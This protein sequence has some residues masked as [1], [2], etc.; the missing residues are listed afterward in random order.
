MT[1]TGSTADEDDELLDTGVAIIGMAARLPGAADLGAFWQNLRAGVESIE[2]IADADLVASGI[3]P[4]LLGDPH[5]VKA[6]TF[7]EGVD[8]FDADFF[9][10]TPREARLLDPQYR[11]ML[12]CAWE[13]C[14]HAGYDPQTF[15]GSMGVFVGS[16][17][18]TYQQDGGGGEGYTP[19][20]EWLQ[21]LISRD[22][23]YLASQIAHKLNLRG[24]CFTVQTA[25]STSLVAVHLACQ[26]V[27]DGS[28][29]VALAGG[30]TIRLP[31]RAG[32]RYE[33][34]GLVSPDGHCRAFDA[35]A[36]GAVY[37]NGVGIVALKRLRR[38]LA[39][40]DRIRAVIRGSAINND[41]TR[42]VGFMTPG[43]DGQ[44]AVIVEALAMANVDP[45]T[46]GYVECQ[47][48]GA[49]LGDAIE[50]RALAQAFDGVGPGACGI[51]SV[52]TNIGHLEAAAGVAALIKTVL[53]L[54]ARELPPTLHFERANPELGLERTPFYVVDRLRPWV[55]R[56]APRRAGVSS[57]GI[58]GTNAHVVV[59]EAP[60]R[61]AARAPAPPR[62]AELVV[63]SARTAAALEAAA[64]RL[65][66]FVAGHPEVALGDLAYSAATTRAAMEHRLALVVDSRVA[67]ESALDHAARGELV[68]GVARGE[69]G[70]AAAAGAT[71][72]GATTPA[73]I[74]MLARDPDRS[75][76][77]AI[78]GELGAL[79]ARG[80]SVDWKAVFPAGGRRVELP[81]YPFQRERYWI[82]SEPAGAPRRVAAWALRERLLAVPEAQRRE[83][84][85]AL[86]RDEVAAVLGLASAAI[87]A[88]RPLQE[89]GLS[90]VM[91]VELRGRLAARAE[92][93][94]PVT[95][96]FDYPTVD[97]LAGALLARAFAGPAVTETSH[98]R[99]AHDEPIAIIAMACR[100]PG[101]A[102]SPEGYWQILDEGRDGI[103]PF[104]ARWD[105]AA[106]YDPDPEARGKSYIREGGFLPDV[107]RFDAAFFGISPREAIAMDPQQRLLLEVA[108]EALERAGIPPATLSESLTGVYVGS[109]GSDYGFGQ[110]LEALD[111]HHST[112][113]LQSVLS[114][115]LS[116][117]LGLQGPAMTV[118]TACSSSLVALHLACAGLRQGECDLA[119]AGGV[120]VMSTPINFVE[121]SRLRGL[122]LDGRCK[123][124]SAAADGTGWSE[125]AGLV[126]LK[127]LSD[128]RRDGDR[129]LAVLRGSAV[130]QDGK[131]QGLTAP[132]GPSQVRVIRRALSQSGLGP[133]DIDALEAHGTGTS[134]GDPIEAAALAEVFGPT[135]EGGSPVWLGSCKSNLGHTL[136]AAGVLGVMKMVLALGHERLPRTLHVDVPTPHVEWGGSGLALLQEGR[137]WPRRADR[138]RRAGVSAFGISGT[139]GHIIVE[140]AP[141]ASASEP[142][143]WGEAAVAADVSLA[144]PAA[145][146][147][148]PVLLSARSEAALREQAARLRE[149]LVARPELPLIDV[150]Y[151]LATTRSQL[152]HRAALVAADRQGLFDALEAAAQG[153][154]A[155][156]AVVGQRLGG[157]K[158]AVL[159]TG[160]GSQRPG[161]GRALYDAF[162]MFRDA[163]DAA[164]AHF[165]AGLV[166]SAE[167]AGSLREVVFA[168]AGDGAAAQLAQ[169][170]LTQPA[171]FAL[172]VA[173]F[174]LLES[175]GL[176][177][178][179]LL[180]H[181]IGE[182]VAAHVGGVLTLADA[183]TL[184][185]ARA[186]LM[187][188][189]RGDGAMVAVQAPEAEVR[190]W[191]AARPE[192]E[193]AAGVVIAAVNGPASTVISGD[194]EAVR[195]VVGRAEA[196][197]HKTQ[198]LRV[199][200]A[201][202]SHHMDGM[203]AAFGE[204]AA[205]VSYQPARIPI[206]SN[207]SG[208]LATDDELR[209]PGYW[210]DHV[211]RAVRFLDGVRTLYAEGARTFLELGPH[212]VLSALAHEALAEDVGE[213]G[214]FIPVMRQGAR[215]DQGGSEPSRAPGARE[216][217]LEVETLISALGALHARGQR[218]DWTA[219]FGG[220]EGVAGDDQGARR[221]PRRVELPT[222]AFQRQRFWLDTPKAR[223][224][225]IA[226]AG[227]AP[228]DHPLLGAAVALADT[229]GV[230][231][232]GRLSLAEHPWLAGHAVFGTVILP[233][234]AFVELALV[235][236]HRAGLD[237]V[238]ELVLEAPLAIPA[239]GAVV[240]QVSVGAPDEAG[241]R[242][243]TVHARAE[244][245][246]SG[247]GWIRHA[248]GALA[249]A[250]PAAEA[251]ASDLRVWP[252][253]GA[254][255]LALDGGDGFYAQLAEAGLAYG[256]DFQGLRGVWRR[257]DE[258]FAEVALPDGIAREAERFVLHPALLDAA[259]HAL[260]AEGRGERTD[261]ALPFSFRGVSLRAV[262]ASTLRV[263]F[264]RGDTAGASSLSIADGAGEPV[265]QIEALITRPASAAQVR[266]A[267]SSQLE[268]LLRVEWSELPGTS[269]APH[270]LERWAMIGVAG[271]ADGG[272]RDVPGPQLPGVAIERHPDLAA[273]RAA[274]DQGAV[275]PDV[276]VIARRSVGAPADLIAAAHDATAKLLAQLQAWLA[277]ERLASSR[278]VVLTCGAVAAR[279]AEGVADLVHAPLWGLV[280]S[281]QSEH[282]DRAILLVDSDDSEA[283]RA[284]RFTGFPPAERQ[285]A[286]RDGACLVPRLAPARASGVQEP[287][288]AASRPLAPG[289]T[290]LVTGGTGTLGALLARHLV[291]VHGVRHLVLVSRRGPAAPGAEALARELGGHGAHV[292]LAACDAADRSALAAVLAAI[293]RAHP[294][295][296]VVHAAGALDDGVVTSLTPERLAAV[297]GAKLD[298][299][300]HLHELTRSLDLSAFVLFSSVA[301]VLGSPGQANYAAANVV[302]DA[303]AQ[304]RRAAGLPALSL[305]WGYWETRTGLSAH[306]SRTDLGRIAR[307][308]IRPLA[309]AEG[310]ALFDA[311][312]LRPDAVLVPARFDA[313][314]LRSHADAL[315]PVL[316][317]LVR[318]HGARP[319]ATRA[320]E[321]SSLQQRLGALPA[322]DRE[323]A[324]LEL[325]CAE[326]ATVL[327]IADPSTVVPERPLKEVGLDSLM[328]LELRGRLAA[329]TAIRFHAT[330]LFDHPTPR[331]LAALLATELFGEERARQRSLGPDLERLERSILAATEDDAARPQVVA[332]LRSLLSKVSRTERADDAAGSDDFESASD[333]ELFAAFDK[334]FAEGDR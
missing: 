195:E 206:V 287:E 237:R 168:A 187:Q 119:L 39:D 29:E 126:V 283:S 130:N 249:P 293:P 274:L 7:L 263:R 143:P 191:I 227:L 73:G 284:V 307:A 310:L 275:V 194:A 37:G 208:R 210:V 109:M 16:S 291:A 20:L 246:P 319:L 327:G 262:G 9:G 179:L 68:A 219:F 36:R 285:L 89:L 173:L 166:E 322:A 94:L 57:F 203:L 97:A 318:G 301:G 19:S 122:A 326:V 316:R 125:G 136:A 43:V 312:L 258:R 265:A 64:V 259:L 230:V 308:G 48:T 331:A 242:S 300:V 240:V 72:A 311:A 200:H 45:A 140:E 164:C 120:S 261:I 157:G 253:P 25:C 76:R 234:T 333:E 184:V 239:R 303:L 250:A 132:N 182:L 297:L 71:A 30:A 302:L 152:E 133:D 167:G 158:L 60:V 115:R 321:A 146:S 280:R 198:R 86:V 129:V 112:G 41:G 26:S 123:A 107:D 148:V 256:A 32:Y 149:H 255:A 5:H 150:A 178:D 248:S 70:P 201:F 306:L 267:G 17:F 211:R 67:L 177:V 174:R 294:L 251:A 224:A 286:L 3:D 82:E 81:T 47:G 141:I 87:P 334:G 38:A 279:P 52:K 134:L 223:G 271:G 309:E 325:V 92:A 175:W 6:G 124:F 1:R 153:R 214:G 23:D 103:G 199:S 106:L 144:S 233:G 244:D 241:R 35:G 61:A 313:A 111:G 78:L 83:V 105:V 317:G 292:T 190:A 183:C 10:L 260:V 95:I 229:E 172:E 176:E 207:L 127:R 27:L 88:E 2:R 299:A 142:A 121:F 84:V 63:I 304:Q 277:D 93:A 215:G 323:R 28:A 131:S 15:A 188:A 221:R 272:S 288:V 212:G 228:A 66:A 162:P 85:R 273:L 181:S 40:G 320:A 80:A 138:I 44:A 278:L 314:A 154:P 257:G 102:V 108:W 276:V 161:M 202:H 332:W 55:A 231:L 245:A 192:G 14:E 330:L 49:P 268:A 298:T 165:D 159:F 53:A 110:A 163:F 160:Q 305:A 328:A 147:A 171:L 62:S 8:R 196:A 329:A 209:S 13:V 96:V 128:A 324:L 295:T 117:V 281:A 116:Y 100:T 282:P 46:V 213:G 135:R 186:R 54:E 18:S 216:G 69:A 74:A 269:A 50:I 290:V 185:G 114:G 4:A 236:A 254:T 225:D 296:A 264:R 204:V 220:R 91:A 197:G 232:T 79:W 238:D 180:G 33:E 169:T 151:S 235:A 75:D 34:G 90:S 65:R 118:D 217:Q 266:A 77:R 22:R 193:A 104:P 222:Y 226:S 270:G 205:R 170:G 56:G 21:R 156:G 42:K 51:G 155:P 247:A 31:Q 315:H 58:G 101:G 145:S 24:P 99:P 289:G 11:L 218:L 137:P 59:E 252:P 243:L 98:L 12:E 189:L 113:Q 139:N